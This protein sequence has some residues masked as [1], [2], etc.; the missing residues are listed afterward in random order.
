VFILGHRIWPVNATLVPAIVGLLAASGLDPTVSLF[1]YFAVLGALGL[2][3]FTFMSGGPRR[4]GW[5]LATFLVVSAVVAV[6][7]MR[8][9]P[10][11]QPRVE[12]AVAS[13]FAEG[14]TGL[15]E[16]SRLG[17]FGELAVSNRVVLRVWTAEPRLL[18]AYVH[19]QFDGREWSSPIRVDTPPPPP[20]RPARASTAQEWL[21]GVPGPVFVIPPEEGLRAGAPGVV[22]TR[23]LQSEIRDWPLLVPASPL[24][25]RAPTSQLTRSREGVLRWPPYE[26]ALLYGVVHDGAGALSAASRGAEETF[27]ARA[28][29]LGL[30][31]RLDPRVRVLA[32]VLASDTSSERGRLQNTV[33]WLRSGYTYSLDVG[34]FETEDPLA[35]FLFNKK[36]GYC[37][38]FATAA[39]VL[40]RLQGVPT[41]YV[42]GFS[43]GP[44]NFVPGRFGVGDHHL[45]RESDA[46]AW[47]EA[48]IPG[49]GWIEADPTPPADFSLLHEPASG[50][51]APLL[52]A[53]RVHAFRI[54]ARLRHE[55]LA[56]LWAALTSAVG[57]LFAGLWQHRLVTGAVVVVLL[58]AASRPWWRAVRER[59]RSR[60]RARLDRQAALPGDLGTLLSSVERH[61]ERQGRP[62][63]PS[64]GL[65]E[66]LDSLP[67]EVL[68]PAARDAS[69]EVVDACYRSAF[70]G[71]PPSRSTVDELRAAVARMS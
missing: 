8:F 6:G 71:R 69:A 5:P 45:V 28:A 43:V 49:E 20:L 25:V 55:G 40:L 24:L 32:S 59:L 41:R 38:Y 61:W 46:H 19:H 52:E 22:E 68:T 9:L 66:H 57:A 16:Q 34:E 37:E 67:A 1:T 63:P 17:E 4:L 62:R 27:T 64:R 48:Y 10:W 21:A 51:L 33:Q 53:A 65:R 13:T 35:E 30:P 31:G 36:K 7:A 23:V 44:Q 39:A 12:R 54:W 58:V 14:T 26:P 2:W 56:G 47:V 42:M 11:A 70:G 15:S 3:A 60:R 29:A 50:G 18:R